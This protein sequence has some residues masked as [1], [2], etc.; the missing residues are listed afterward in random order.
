MSSRQ[1]VQC[2]STVARVPQGTGTGESTD[3]LAEAH[4]KEMNRPVRTRTPGGVG[5]AAQQ[6]G[7]DP[8]SAGLL[9]RVPRRK[10]GH[11][12]TTDLSFAIR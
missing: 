4:C 11:V 3:N 6:S 9:V 10:F 5:G 8:G 7:P 2:R 1:A 12:P